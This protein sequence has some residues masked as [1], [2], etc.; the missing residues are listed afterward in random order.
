MKKLVNP[1]EFEKTDAD[2]QQEANAANLLFVAGIVVGTVLL[3]IGSTLI[4][5]ALEILLGR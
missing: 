5:Y 1:D 4:I 3:L 2:Y